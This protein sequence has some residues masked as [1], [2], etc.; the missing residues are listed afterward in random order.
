MRFNFLLLLGLSW[1]VGT[2]SLPVGEDGT[3]IEARA[4]TYRSVAYFVNWVRLTN[5]L[6]RISINCYDETRAVINCI[7]I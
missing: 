5:H 3:E 6:E 1:A 4:S 2:T 7:S